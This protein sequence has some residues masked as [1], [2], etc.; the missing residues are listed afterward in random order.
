MN[1]IIVIDIIMM[2]RNYFPIEIKTKDINKGGF[3]PIKTLKTTCNNC[4]FIRCI[5]GVPIE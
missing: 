2:Y 5:I 4:Q 1:N 3:N